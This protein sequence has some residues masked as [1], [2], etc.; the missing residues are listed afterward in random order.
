MMQNYYL[1]LKQI[2]YLYTKVN[3]QKRFKIKIKTSLFIN[4]L[5]FKLVMKMLYYKIFKNYLIK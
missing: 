1:L 2:F 3:L 5:M 4:M